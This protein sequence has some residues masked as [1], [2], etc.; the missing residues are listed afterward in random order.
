MTS[1]KNR[2]VYILLYIIDI[3]IKHI[4]GCLAGSYRWEPKSWSSSISTTSEKKTWTKRRYGKRK[5]TQVS[6]APVVGVSGK[7]QVVLPHAV[8][9][10]AGSGLC[11]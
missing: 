6:C 2:F 10:C 8:N 11:K 4:R 5:S 9:D 7:P 3:A 1:F